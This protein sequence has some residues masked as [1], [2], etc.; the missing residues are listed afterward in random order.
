MTIAPS[1]GSP[2]TRTVP[3]TGYR[4]ILPSPHPRIYA[5]A[6]RIETAAKGRCVFG[7]IL[8]SISGR[9]TTSNA[10]AVGRKR[11]FHC[12]PRPSTYDSNLVACSS[13]YPG[14]NSGEFAM[15]RRSSSTR[16]QTNRLEDGIPKR[17][18]NWGI[19]IC[20]GLRTAAGV[21]DCRLPGGEVDSR[22]IRWQILSAQNVAGGRLAKSS[23]KT[24]ID[25]SAQGDPLHKIR[26]FSARRRQR[27]SPRG[28]PALL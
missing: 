20:S 24:A 7:T 6:R 15:N 5:T 13:I 1:A 18:G 12:P 16:G 3:F 2:S 19:A 11:E 21:A 14:R 28:R 8:A 9:K 23:R 17:V 26:L 25:F 22:S 27:H 4:R 10:R